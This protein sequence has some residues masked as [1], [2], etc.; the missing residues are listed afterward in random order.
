MLPA[1]QDPGGKI[2][3]ISSL[4]SSLILAWL[5]L[6]TT[7]GVLALL[8]LW[9]LAEQVQQSVRQGPP[10]PPLSAFPQSTVLGLTFSLTPDVCIILLALLCG[11]LGSIVHA[12][13]RLAQAATGKTGKRSFMRRRDA[14]WFIVA[15]FQGG[16]LAFF[17][18]SAIAAGLFTAGSTSGA[19]SLSLF[20]V[21][22]VAGLTGLFTKRMTVRLALLINRVTDNQSQAE[23]IQK[24][25]SGTTQQIT[26]QV[27]SP[28]GSE[29]GNHAQSAKG[30]VVAGQASPAPVPPNGQEPVR[31]L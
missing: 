25:A 19:G 28:V 17:V 12:L 29:D 6:A 26:G 16:L 21:A 30:T 31:E 18:V 20:T 11:T 14:T 5:L 8:L 3:R 2:P 1:S 10:A 27:N 13:T 7:G 22:S 9:P 15:P 24:A 23:A 4:A